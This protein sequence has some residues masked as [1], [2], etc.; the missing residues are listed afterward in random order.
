MGSGL[1]CLSGAVVV[2]F[3]A[4]ACRFGTRGDL[5]GWCQSQSKP[6]LV[7]VDFPVHSTVLSA[8]HGTKVPVEGTESSSDMFG[9]MAT[10]MGGEPR[11]ATRTLVTPHE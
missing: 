6:W 4:G 1:T 5:E 11:F 7:P 8:L 3:L 2:D 10:G 9:S